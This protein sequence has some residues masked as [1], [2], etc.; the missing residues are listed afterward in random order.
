MRQ[1]L[2]R[3]VAGFALATSLSVT[4]SCELHQPK[5]SRLGATTSSRPFSP[6]IDLG[7][8]VFLAGQIGQDPAT[9]KLVAGGIEAETHQALRNLGA[10]LREAGL[11]YSDVVKASVFLADIEDFA[12]MNAVYAEYFPADGMPPVRTTVAVAALARGSRVEID[13]IAAR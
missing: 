1:L 3:S 2:L 9:G 5:K 4:T 8:L 7:D 6:G 10:V 12:A 13:F 11:D